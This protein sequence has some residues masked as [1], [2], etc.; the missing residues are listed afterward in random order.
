ML[1]DNKLMKAG[2]ALL[3]AGL[4]LGLAAAWQVRTQMDARLHEDWPRANAAKALSETLIPLASGSGV[5][6]V[7]LTA[8]AFYRH[9]SRV[10][11]Y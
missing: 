7:L 1:H 2:L 3:F 9:K 6:G 10:R 8:F 5:S 4:I 11:N